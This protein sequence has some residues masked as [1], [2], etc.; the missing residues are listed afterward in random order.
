MKI[1]VCG[2][3][4]N[5]SEVVALEP[6][7]VGFIFYPKSKRYVGGMSPSAL[8]GIPP[9]VKKVGVFV[10]QPI[11][12]VCEKVNRYGL[13]LVQLHGHEPVEYCQ[14][15]KQLSDAGVIKVF[16][17]N[18]LPDEATLAAYGNVIDYY[19]FDTRNE[20][21]GG[22][23][24]K[25][26]WSVLSGLKL[27]KPLF[28]SGGIAL[29]DFQSIQNSGIPIYALDVNSKFEVRPGLKDVECLNALFFR[30]KRAAI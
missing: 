22:T 11:E 28:L 2:L 17:G 13:N 8:D 3:R 14:T 19:L 25:F 29:D 16:S 5:I 4:D 30:A 9:Q 23:G 1:K 7:F 20:S 24:Q 12:E 21:Y 10:D 27:K 6:D 18:D 15:V 26:D